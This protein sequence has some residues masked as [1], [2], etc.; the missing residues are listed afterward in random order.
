MTAPAGHMKESRRETGMLKS[1]TP[2]QSQRAM[3]DPTYASGLFAISATEL[4]LRG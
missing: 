2:P 4:I 1:R 3:R